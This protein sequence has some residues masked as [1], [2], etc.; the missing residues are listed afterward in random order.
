MNA[1]TSYAD[2]SFFDM[3]SFPLVE[4]DLSGWKA[5]R[6]GV[7]VSESFAK[8]QFGDKDPVGREIRFDGA[9]STVST[10]VVSGV[11]KD[12]GNSIIKPCDIFLRGRS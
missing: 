4:G 3:F 1:V 2:S 11:L 10:L 9:D 7:L 8:A 6:S 5:S 12:I